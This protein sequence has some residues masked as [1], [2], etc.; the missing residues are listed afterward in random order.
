VIRDE[1]KG[2]LARGRQVPDVQARLVAHRSR[3]RRR[4]RDGR[5]LRLPHS[6]C[7][8]APRRRAAGGLVDQAVHLRD[9]AAARA[10]RAVDRPRRAGRGP[11]RDRDLGAVELQRGKY[12]G[13]ITLKTALAKSIN[14]VSVRPRRRH[15][16]R[17]R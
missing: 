7:S 16:R 3:D 8:T 4:A 13:A 14:T 17:R 2:E 10:T 6:A 1:K 15:G 12:L 5:R 9:R 11:D